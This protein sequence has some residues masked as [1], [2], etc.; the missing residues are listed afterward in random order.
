[1]NQLIN[2]FYYYYV[3]QKIPQESDSSYETPKDSDPLHSCQ[4][5]M[6]TKQ[7]LL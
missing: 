3:E 1:M 5:E 7:V 4:C 2:N 6:S